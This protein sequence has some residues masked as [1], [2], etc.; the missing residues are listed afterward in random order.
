MTDQASK[1][2][3]KEG[4][5]EDNMKPSVIL[6]K[7]LY[8]IA[9]MV[10]VI[11]FV[12]VA[13]GY[14]NAYAVS[15]DGEEVALVE[16]PEVAEE[17]L[18]EI[19]LDLGKG[20]EVALGAD[21]GYKKIHS[22]DETASNGEL[23][24][25]FKEHLNFLCEAAAVTVDGEPKVWVED[26]ETAERVIERIRK[27]FVPE[28]EIELVRVDFEEKVESQKGRVNAEKIVDAAA[29]EE[30]LRNGKVK[31]TS[32]IIEEGDS[33]WTIARANNTR[34]K[35]ILEANPG[36]SEDSI[37]SLG[38]EVK[39]T[40]TEPMVNVIAEYN[41]TVVK[42]IPKETKYRDDGNL[43]SGKTKVIKKG[44]DGEKEV[45][46]HVVT[47]NG[48]NISAEPVSKKVTKEPV[49]EL[50]AKGTKKTTRANYTVAS[51]SSSGGGG[52]SLSWPTRGS[53]SSR[54]SY[55]G[56]E[57][58]GAIDI[59]ARSGTPITAAAGG[60]VTT[61]GWGGGYGN[62]IV[63]N[64]GGGMSTRYA[65]CS[66][67]NVK[68]GQKVSQGQVIGRVGATGRATGA[69]LHFEVMVNGAKKNPINYLR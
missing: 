6:S 33:L 39:L 17:V 3:S 18:E 43:Q 46:Y 68:V 50:V 19:I 47:T 54:Y 51:R 58:H 38:Q 63:I 16:S 15:I 56:R 20:R 27:C 42:E 53:I 36:L 55:R 22:K 5:K 35:H 9:A 65:H 14:P 67:L 48:V 69:H 57:F 24:K 40:K 32:H 45:V 41:K 66:A 26:E 21:I 28:G 10:L 8:L 23:S 4:S 11:V 60:T 62:Q 61:A 44:E 2:T 34:V 31:V 25:I 30:L 1:E 59:A 64:H 29:A 49:A 12:A 7:P 52:G 13:A 37:L